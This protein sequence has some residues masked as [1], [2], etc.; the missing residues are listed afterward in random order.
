MPNPPPLTRIDVIFDDLANMFGNTAAD[1]L[2]KLLRIGLPMLVPVIV[3]I[4]SRS[5]GK[6]IVKGIFHIV[7]RRAKVK[8]YVT[9]RNT[10]MTDYEDT[11]EFPF[12]NTEV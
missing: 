11:N 5:V 2:L 12:Y 1:I 10:C 8:N 3:I 7:A 6:L 4:L 9:F